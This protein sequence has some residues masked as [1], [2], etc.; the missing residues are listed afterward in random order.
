MPNL[1]PV[2][3]RYDS[4]CCLNTSVSADTAFS[5]RTIFAVHN[6]VEAMC[7]NDAPLVMHCDPLLALEGDATQFRFVG[8]CFFVHA[9]NEPWPKR[10]MY[11]KHRLHYL[12]RQFPVDH[13]IILRSVH[14]LN[15]RVMCSFV[16]FVISNW[17]HSIPLGQPF[18]H[19]EGV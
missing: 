3:L 6:E 11:F 17:A 16:P 15:I 2:A 12:V 5:S 4:V 19:S 10:V 13:F 9:L 14:L 18:E 7:A 8:Q 1:K